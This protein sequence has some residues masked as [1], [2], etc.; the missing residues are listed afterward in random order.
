MLSPERN[1]TLTSVGPD[2]PMGNLMR[3]YWLPVLLSSELPDPDCQPVRVRHLGEKLVAFRDTSGTVGLL[4]EFCPHRRASL[5]LGR[6]EEG[7]L[8]CVYHGWKFDTSGACIDLP[9]EPP[10]SSFKQRVRTKSYPCIE[11]GGAIWAYL[12][13]GEPPAPPAFEWMAVRPEQRFVSKRLLEC[14][15]AQALE[16]DI[17]SSHASILHSRLNPADY[18]EFEGARELLYFD[19]DRYPR[20]EVFDT[21]FGMTMAARRNAEPG[22]HYWRGAQYIM[23]IFVMIAPFDDP[24]PQMNMWVPMDDGNTMVWALHWHP[25]RNLTQDELERRG[26]NL[27]FHCTQFEDGTSE[28]GSSWIPKANSRN[29]YLADAEVQRTKMYSGIEPLWCQDKAVQESMGTITDRVHEHLA[30]SDLAISRWRQKIL[31]TV[32]NPVQLE[33]LPGRDPQT[34]RVR[35]PH[36][37]APENAD[38]RSRMEEESRIA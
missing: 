6:N 28:A 27:Y 36:F 3:S 25:D 18:A 37:V 7:G 10:T 32:E 34:H 24:L 9:S 26:S 22:S 30:P 23:P 13:E 33:E 11:A 1:R 12:G 38:W 20:Y 14:N 35:P 4:D 5:V 31:A 29:D 8:R 17:D 19:G 21:D 15:W 16:G 2:T